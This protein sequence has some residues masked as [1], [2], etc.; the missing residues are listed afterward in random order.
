MI[1]PESLAGIVVTGIAIALI[2]IM[3]IMK[4][5]KTN[6]G[7]FPQHKNYINDT[8]VNHYHSHH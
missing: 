5:V 6:G 8:N 2:I 4:I 7:L 1:V 3:V